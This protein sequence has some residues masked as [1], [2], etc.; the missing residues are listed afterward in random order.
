VRQ[1]KRKTEDFD[2]GDESHPAKKQR[3]SSHP[4]PSRPSTIKKEKPFK[5]KKMQKRKVRNDDED[6]DEDED[7]D[8]EERPGPS[9]AERRK[10]GR[11]ASKRKS[12]ADR[13]DSEDD[14]EMWNGVAQWEF[15]PDGKNGR[16]RLLSEEREVETPESEAAEEEE[17]ATPEPEDVEEEEE[18]EATPSPP[19]SNGRKTTRKAPAARK[20]KSP[21]AS[22]K[23]P[24]AKSSPVKS[25]AVKPSAVKQ[26][27]RKGPA[28]KVVKQKQ[29][30]K[31]PL[32][33]KKLKAA[34]A[35]K[36]VAKGRGRSGKGKKVE[37]VKDI[38]DMDESE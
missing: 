35:E 9:S 37:K 32:V 34:V 10:S 29:K 2:D 4:K 13:D 26:P 24:P 11:S 38:F 36:P 17:P 3:S 22:A 31:S 25:S 8:E 7:A 1:S 18:R 19:K 14:K 5:E 30:A 28:S 15:I 27:E 23:S 12:Y 33:V 20:A 21:I 6:E 16:K